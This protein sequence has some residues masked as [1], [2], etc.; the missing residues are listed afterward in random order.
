M[1]ELLG[2]LKQH[3]HCL[4]SCKDRV[5]KERKRDGNA[6]AIKWQTREEANE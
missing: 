3:F 4:K 5:E 6:N 1:N 2:N